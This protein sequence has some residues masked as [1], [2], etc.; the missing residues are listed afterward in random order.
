MTRAVRVLGLVLLVVGCAAWAW[1]AALEGPV[2]RVAAPAEEVAGGTGLVELE[3]YVLDLRLAPLLLAVAGVGLLVAGS[4]PEY[5][6]GVAA[7]SA[8]VGVTL[9]VPSVAQLFAA[10]W[11]GA[12]VLGA[13]L[14]GVVVLTVRLSGDVVPQG[15]GLS[16]PARRITATVALVMLCSALMIEAFVDF[17]APVVAA[18][19]G[20]YLDAVVILEALVLGSGAIALVL[21][22]RQRTWLHPVAC[23]LAVALWVV[24]RATGFSPAALVLFMVLVVTATVAAVAGERERV[25][26]RAVAF[27]AGL[28]LLYPFAAYMAVLAGIG[29]GAVPL[30][31]NGGAIEYDGL[32]MFMAG[33]LSAAYPVLLYM[34]ATETRNVGLGSGPAPAAMADGSRKSPQACLAEPLLQGRQQPR[35]GSDLAESYRPPTLREDLAPNTSRR[36]ILSSV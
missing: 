30:A 33:P 35:M 2:D 24:I 13:A 27:T 17:D 28:A 22:A 15:E 3:L 23:L 12:A 8:A 5:F 19:P 32:P 11:L 26:S 20:R 6:H 4:V 34:I 36:V 1:V 14:F 25:W 9:V 29:V 10:W 7:M 18:L 16:L 21:A 31:L